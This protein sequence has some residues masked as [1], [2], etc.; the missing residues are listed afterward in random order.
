MG[1][2]LI[3]PGAH[4]VYWSLEER[5]KNTDVADTPYCDEEGG[6]RD[7]FRTGFFVYLEPGQVRKIPLPNS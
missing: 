7:E 3:P 1:I 5:V 2:R 6:F 4:F